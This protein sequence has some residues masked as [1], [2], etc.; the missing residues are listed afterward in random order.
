[1]CPNMLLYLLLSSLVCNLMLTLNLLCVV[2]LMNVSYYF[3]SVCYRL[4][5]CCELQVCIIFA[6]HQWVAYSCGG[7]QCQPAPHLL[8]S[9]TCTLCSIPLLKVPAVVLDLYFSTL[10]RYVCVK[11]ISFC[12]GQGEPKRW[13]L[14]HTE[15]EAYQAF[16]SPVQVLSSVSSSAPLSGRILLHN[17][18]RIRAEH[19]N[20]FSAQPRSSAQEAALLV[21]TSFIG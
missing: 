2:P 14:L 8:P 17:F 20:A 4:T 3:C 18:T 1:M 9:H 19:I 21:F 5:Q 10:Y 13:E 6:D 11:N 16:L 7:P 15:H 12:I